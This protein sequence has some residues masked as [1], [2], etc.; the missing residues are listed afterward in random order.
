VV[1]DGVGKPAPSGTEL[2]AA[3][4]LRRGSK[5]PPEVLF[6]QV[7][8]DARVEVAAL[9]LRPPGEI[10]FCIGSGGCTALSLLTRGLA[11]LFVVDINPAQIYLLEL[12]RAAFERLPYPSMLECLTADT[13]SFY[14]DLRASLTP[15]AAA[16]W[17][18]RR[19]LLQQGLGRCGLIERRLHRLTRLVLPLVHRPRTIHAMFHPVDLAAQQQF[20][21]VHWDNRQWK[22]L[23]RWGLSRPA[24]RQL[25]G[26]PFVERIPDGFP[27]LVK[28]RVDAAFLD[29]PI[30]EN[31][32]LWQAFLG[33][34]PPGEAGLPIFLRRENHAQLRGALA[35]MALFAADAAGWLERQPAS[36]IGFFALSN[37]FEVTSSEYARR[38]ET[39]LW[40]AARPGAIVCS[41]TIFPP[42]PET[43]SFSDDRFAAE[44]DL[45]EELARSDRSLLCK[46]IQVFRV[47]K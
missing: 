25:Y 36:S 19:H 12:K 27:D 13:S 1:G 14:P 2:W 47:R 32:Y 7:H 4:R 44:R 28:Q 41:R 22:R 29:F 46:F 20:Y 26:K 37:I 24:L 6:G 40:Q 9:A 5:G 18:R 42:G 17:D 34:Y 35:R 8:E 16:F 10:A 15:G 31:S 30:Q 21:R 38:L 33:T 3:G 45:S 43:P 39:A 23:F 11:K